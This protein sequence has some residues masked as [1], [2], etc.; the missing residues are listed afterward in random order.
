MHIKLFTLIVLIISSTTLQAQKAK[1]QWKFA[2]KK[3]QN[4]KIEIVMTATVPS[5]W[6]IY[7]QFT[8]EG[9]VATAF[10]FNNNALVQLDGAVKEKGKLITINDDIWKNKQKFYSGTVQFVQVVKLKAK[11]KTN[12]SGE[13]EYMICDDSSCLPPTTQKFNITL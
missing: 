2:S 8:G 3:V 7:S 11:I 1:V 9:P 5:G 13:V 4:D 10:T 12:I 6:H